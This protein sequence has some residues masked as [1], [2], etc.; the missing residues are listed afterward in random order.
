MSKTSLFFKAT[1]LSLGLMAGLHK[2][3][4]TQDT[5]TTESDMKTSDGLAHHLGIIVPFASYH[6]KPGF[7]QCNLGFAP[8]YQIHIPYFDKRHFNTILTAGEYDNSFG[9]ATYF[10]GI[11]AYKKAGKVFRYGAMAM[12]SNYP[13][14]TE[15][16]GAHLHPQKSNY[17]LPIIAPRLG[18]AFTINHLSIGADMEFGYIPMTGLIAGFNAHLQMD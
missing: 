4:L 6:S 18:A 3:G 16:N 2:Q 5:T 7:K 13:H 11:A 15:D 8:S 17:V 1:M 9:T 12:L 10:A 14:L